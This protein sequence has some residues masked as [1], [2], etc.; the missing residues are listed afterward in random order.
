MKK[1]KL[2]LK[3][4]S[5]VFFVIILFLIIG[6]YAGIK[7]HNQIEYKKTEEYQFIK[8]GYTKE[9]VSLLKKQVSENILA[10]LLKT[11]K[12]EFLLQLIQEDYYIKSKLS[13]Y[14]EYHNKW[15][16]ESSSRVV[17]LVNTNRDYPYYDYDLDVDFE[18]DY[19]IIT[20]KYYRLNEYEP[21]DLVKVSNEYYY[22]ENHQL[23]KCAYEAFI[24][25]WKEAK[26]EDIYLIITTSYRSY[27]SQMRIYDSYKN[28]QGTTYADS[29]AARPGYSEHQTGLALDIFSKEHSNMTG[30]RGSK[31]HL[32][33][34]N[35]A[36]LFGFIER[37]PE[38]KE[39]ITGFGAEAW[40]YRY[41][42]VNVATYIYEHKITFDEYYAYFIENSES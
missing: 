24:Q 27:S 28:T 10:S 2:K 14:L 31:T 16:S 20:N 39:D 22:G 7:I 41:V 12:D 1:T 9:E 3:K 17:A 11:A 26:K 38:D 30:F 42:G 19:S 23:R 36:H 40:H 37:Y 32:W 21:H 8:I 29:V 5:W 4:Q 34:Q 15:V 25:M 35:H 13:R 33:L 6:V 18:K